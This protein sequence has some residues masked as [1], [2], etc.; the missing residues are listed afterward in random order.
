MDAS[1]IQAARSLVD[2]LLGERDALDRQ[3]LQTKDRISELRQEI[4]ILGY[5]SSLF[6]HLID[7][8]I[9]QAVKSVAAL[10]TD[11][12][13][14]IFFDQDISVVPEISENRG[15]ISVRFL[16]RH[17]SGKNV[18]EGDSLD[19]FGGSI[20]TIQSILLRITV[21]FRRGLRP[22]LLLDETLSA[23]ADKYVDR[24]VK[25]LSS[26]SD[27]LGLDILLVTHD[28][29]IVSMAHHAYQVVRVG[30]EATFQPLSVAKKPTRRVR[31]SV[32]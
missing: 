20:L 9:V 19:S 31:K 32:G 2:K 4:D 16:I 22:L 15:K 27:S 28:D 7:G 8:E 21:L 25:F 30:D 18:V 3:I 17:T 29:A 14:E 5:V 6:R 11:G 23:V 1:R 24:A 10:Q 13:Q 12:L 26:L